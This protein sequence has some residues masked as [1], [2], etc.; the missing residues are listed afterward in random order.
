LESLW[1]LGGNGSGESLRGCQLVLEVAKDIGALASGDESA[2]LASQILDHTLS[3]ALETLDRCGE[4]EGIVLGEVC[5]G[6]GTG[7]TGV[8]IIEETLSSGK[9]SA[10]I[11]T[12]ISIDGS[13]ERT[14]ISNDLGDDGLEDGKLSN[15]ASGKGKSSESHFNGCL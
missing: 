10:C 12:R 2:F 14:D 11:S 3:S 7:D 13:V 15:C 6:F 8:D 1:D 9:D 4:R 5:R